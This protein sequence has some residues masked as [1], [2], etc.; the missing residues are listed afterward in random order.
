MKN[1]AKTELQESTSFAEPAR[2][3]PLDDWA[4][5]I[6]AGGGPAG[7]CAGI[8]HQGAFKSVPEAMGCL[9]SA[10]DREYRPDPSAMT[11]YAPRYQDY[12]RLGA[13]IGC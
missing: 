4:D 12:L 10:T 1:A 2:T 5:V 9:A 11:I 13:S 3:I 8:N 7:G 6:V